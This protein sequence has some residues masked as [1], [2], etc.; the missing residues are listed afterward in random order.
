MLP[1]TERIERAFAERLGDITGHTR[2]SLLIVAL[3]DRDSTSEVLEAA[4]LAAGLPIDL[5][6]LEAAA[7]A[8]LIELD[9]SSVRFRH[10][11]MRSAVRQAAPI[12]RRRRAHEALAEALSDDP[13]RR[14]TP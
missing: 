1:L 2:L 11:L 8:G 12:E 4:A 6:A 5:D 3:N 13:D 7:L 14:G 9:V 10:P